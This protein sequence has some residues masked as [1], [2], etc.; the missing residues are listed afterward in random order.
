MLY[1]IFCT[2][3]VTVLLQKCKQYICQKVILSV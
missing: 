1:F 3:F 2:Y